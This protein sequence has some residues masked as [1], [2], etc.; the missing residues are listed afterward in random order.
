MN[1]PEDL[2]SL[3]EVVIL[4]LAKVSSLEARVAEL[5][6][7]NQAL[8]SGN[9][10]LSS[11]NTA[12]KARL[13]LDSHNSSKPPSSDGLGKKP[14]FPRSSG[15]KRGG[16]DG[17]KGKTLDFSSCPDNIIE[18]KALHCTCGCDLS[19]LPSD[20]ISRRQLFEI[21]EP[22]L[23]VTEY[24]VLSTQ[25]PSCGLSHRG[26]FP[27]GVNAPVQYG[28]R[29]RSFITL[30]NNDCMLSVERIQNLFCDLFGYSINENTIQTAVKI[31]YDKLEST[32]GYDKLE[33]TQEW[34]KSKLI[35]AMVANFDETGL[36]CAGKLHW[37]HVASNQLYTHLFVHPK[38]GK[39]AIESDHSILNHYHQWAVHDCWS[40]YFNMEHPKHAICG[41][42]LLRELQAQIE[43]HSKWAGRFKDFLLETFRTDFRDRI[44]KRDQIETEFD[45]IIQIG[46]LEEPE[47]KKTGEKGKAKRTKGRNLLERLLKYKQEVLAFAFNEIV[48]FTNNQA[49]RDLRPAKVKQKVSGC[50]RTLLGAQHYA[51]IAGFVSTVRKNNLN[52]FNELCNIFDDVPASITIAS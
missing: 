2:S 10:V 51:R 26:E 41:A 8:R 11:E 29:T 35:S 40:S 42:H 48:P 13:N 49:E 32:Q 22:R 19:N 23:E 4:L 39:E 15:N 6:S 36:R 44:E 46:Q 31:C 20:V 43:G 5:E 33:S 28:P 1:I 37:L 50:F 7:D 47:P 45:E 24:R 9:S 34:I 38:R 14:A 12:L 25:C 27:L 3:K 52:V 21:P 17:H 18:C 30:L 16:K